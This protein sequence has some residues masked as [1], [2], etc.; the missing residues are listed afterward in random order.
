MSQAFE[1]VSSPTG[2]RAGEERILDLPLHGYER[3][4]RQRLVIFRQSKTIF[5]LQDGEGYSM[6]IDIR[7]SYCIPW[8]A[9]PGQ[10]NPALSVQIW[11]YEYSMA[12]RADALALQQAFTGYRVSHDW[13]AVEWRI[14]R[15]GLIKKAL[16]NNKH[17]LS[18]IQIWEPEQLT[19]L[20]KN[21]TRPGRALSR[22]SSNTFA[23]S[24]AEELVST[25]PA[26]AASVILQDELGSEVIAA[27]ADALTR[28]AILI[29]T[30]CN[31]KPSYLYLPLEDHVDLNLERCDCGNGTA[32]PSCRCSVI[33]KTKKRKP[34]SI[35][36]CIARDEGDWNLFLFAS[37]KSD[38]YKKLKSIDARELCLRFNNASARIDFEIALRRAIR[39][40]EDRCNGFTASG[41][42][43]RAHEHQPRLPITSPLTT[44]LTSVSHDSNIADS[45]YSSFPHEMRGALNPSTTSFSY[46][47]PE[48][49][50]SNASEYFP[51]NG[52]NTYHNRQ[53]SPQ[54]WNPST[55]TRELSSE[56]RGPCELPAERFDRTELSADPEPSRSRQRDARRR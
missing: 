24:L 23:S 12:S 7:N 53:L 14:E 2:E 25:L 51:A 43:M 34:F 31:G 42:Q 38:K 44:R 22:G 27:R 35:K 9:S 29:F 5:R 55:Q 28:P 6:P 17:E 19:R 16:A 37:P 46:I 4:A 1:T 54:G 41:K 49:R 50:T 30:K 33:E 21:Q 13:S 11:I 56:N 20:E 18:T 52:N 26:G 15:S 47:S 45:A 48:H 36:R 39:N 32:G 40:H 8:Y 3:D 10:S